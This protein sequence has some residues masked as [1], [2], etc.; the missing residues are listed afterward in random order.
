MT[1]DMTSDNAST[2]LASAETLRRFFES[3]S[4]K[5]TFSRQRLE[6]IF[7]PKRA[8]WYEGCWERLF[9]LTKTAI[10]K[11]LGRTLVTLKEL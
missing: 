6:W 3:L 9:G 1:S 11:T 2:Y 10:M 5:E 7:I 4:L 8:P